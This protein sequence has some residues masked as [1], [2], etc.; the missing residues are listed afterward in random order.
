M[1]KINSLEEMRK[2]EVYADNLILSDSYF[3]VR[4]DGRG[5]HTEVKKLGMKR[6]FDR[7]LREALNKSIIEVMKDFNCVFAYTE[8]D[9]CT[10]LFDKDN[11][12]FDRRHEKI[13]SL[14]ASKMSVAFIKQ[15]P[16]HNTS[17]PSFDARVLVLPTK[18]EVIKCFQW[19]QMDS[20][21]NAISTY[22]FWNLVKSGKNERQA[23]KEMVGKNDSYKNEL[24]FSKFGINYNN[25]SNWEKKGT[26]FYWKYY[27]KNG[28]NPITNEKVK[29]I[30]KEIVSED[31]GI[32]FRKDN[33]NKWLN[34][35][36]YKLR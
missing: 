5:F 1:S 28:F 25:V 32:H 17:L 27:K 29:A 24:L 7:I 11:D 9:E 26:M 33:L 19:R 14:V 20:H 36:I 10:F 3:S 22:C 35:G 2:F 34:K 4:V 15:F 31:V 18:E 13:V 12:K 30:R 6:P 21:R 23:Q 8:S 16:N